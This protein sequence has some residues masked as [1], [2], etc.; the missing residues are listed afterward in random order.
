MSGKSDKKL[1][2]AVKELQPNIIE[3]FTSMRTWPFRQRLRMAWLLLKGKRKVRIAYTCSDYVHHEHN[4]KW[5]AWGCGRFQ[6]VK[7]TINPKG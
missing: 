2:K 6:K 1:R 5:T 3:M 4:Y 7:G